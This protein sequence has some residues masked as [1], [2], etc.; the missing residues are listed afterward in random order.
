MKIKDLQPNQT[1]SLEKVEVVSL[2]E[3]KEF[4]KYG[5]VGKLRNLKI[6]DG[7]GEA[8]LTLWNDNVDDFAEGDVLKLTD[9]WIKEWNGNLQISSG[10]KGKIE[11][12]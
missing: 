9:C 2:G 8:D 4:N 7:S 1:A 5:N 11:K 10:K 6:K 3:V 12:I